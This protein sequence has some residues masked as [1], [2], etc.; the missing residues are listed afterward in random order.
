MKD[1]FVE[2]MGPDVAI[3]AA[4]ILEGKSLHNALNQYNVASVYVKCQIPQLS[5]KCGIFLLRQ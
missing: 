2:L 3:G 5:N 1:Q 4:I